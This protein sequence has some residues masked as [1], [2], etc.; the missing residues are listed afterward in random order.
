METLEQ[1][2]QSEPVSPRQLNPLVDRDLETVCLK[3]LDKDPSRRYDSAQ[4]LADELQ[5]YIDDRPITARPIGRLA[6]TARW[7]RRRPAMATLIIALSVALI[8]GTIVST[9]YAYRA[10]KNAEHFRQQEMR[11][12]AETAR[13]VG[14][15]ESEREA[16]EKLKV[17]LAETEKTI[18]QWVETTQRTELLR[19]P[20][21]YIS[22]VLE[23]G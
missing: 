3:C 5:R 9:Y 8:G 19:E 22:K 14:A 16:L 11:A 20:R 12:N 1:V 4:A 18:E 2:L 23:E 21:P 15:L 17:S 6:R 10:Q 7:C 13:A